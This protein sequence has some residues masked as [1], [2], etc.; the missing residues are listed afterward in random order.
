MIDDQNKSRLPHWASI[1][2][3]VA[4]VLGVFL[5][6]MHG[7]EWMKH[8]VI[9]SNMPASGVMP[10]ADCPAEEL[11]EEGLSLAQCEFLVDNL[12]GFVESSPEGFS[13][14]MQTLALVGAILAFAS[15]I[16]GGALVNYTQW[17]ANAAIIV[18]VGLA[19]IDVLQFS[20]VVGAG[21]LLRN[22]YLWSVMLWLILHAMLLV[23]AIAGRQFEAAKA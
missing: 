19:L 17:S 11:E 23:G 7:T 1:L 13:G 5:T 22:F 16:I 4:I 9:A 18:F 6:A 21:P 8:S 12:A 2:G 14:S 20:V 15:V 3:V 10:A